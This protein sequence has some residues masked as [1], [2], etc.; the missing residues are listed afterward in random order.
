ML[1]YVLPVLVITVSSWPLRPAH[2]LG[3]GTYIGG[4]A[5]YRDTQSHDLLPA[6]GAELHL[7][8]SQ[9]DKAPPD[10][11][12][13]LDVDYSSSDKSTAGIFV[14][15]TSE[16]HAVVT[17][18]YYPWRHDREERSAGFLPKVVATR[19]LHKDPTWRAKLR[20]HLTPTDASLTTSRSVGTALRDAWF[21]KGASVVAD[22]NKDAAHEHFRADLQVIVSMVPAEQRRNLIPEAIA[23]LRKDESM[24]EIGWGNFEAEVEVA[25]SQDRT[26]LDNIQ[27]QQKKWWAQFR[28]KPNPD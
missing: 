16:A 28:E 12:R 8:A 5:L 9:H 14:L 17:I 4:E 27:E 2:A 13:R 19:Q 20:L 3:D 24:A 1:R 6:P 11:Y 7:I 22:W 10:T 18:L 21:A 23:I 26:V 25:V 15:G